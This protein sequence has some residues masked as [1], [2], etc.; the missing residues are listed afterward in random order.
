MDRPA[1]SQ[2]PFR[3][4][5]NLN[6]VWSDTRR[7]KMRSTRRPSEENRENNANQVQQSP[8]QMSDKFVRHS[9]SEE[10]RE[11]N[12]NEQVEEESPEQMNDK[13]HVNLD[14]SEFTVISYCG[15]QRTYR[16]SSIRDLRE[17]VADRYGVWDHHTD[18]GQ[19]HGGFDLILYDVS[20]PTPG[21]CLE[22]TDVPLALRFQGAPEPYEVLAYAQPR[23]RCRCE[24]CR[25]GHGASFTHDESF[26]PPSEVGAKRHREW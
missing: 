18:D 1:A 10:N 22:D 11:N 20:R 16:A 7:S 19:H 13:F 23:P 8:E 17:Q 21:G 12:A 14:R 2:D 6:R 3:L 26:L 25:A 15:H 4:N 5:Y 24:D 9:P